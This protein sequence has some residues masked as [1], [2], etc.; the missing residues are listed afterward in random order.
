[1]MDRSISAVVDFI[2]AHIG[3]TV[4]S[5][6]QQS[7]AEIPMIAPFTCAT[8]GPAF[9]IFIYWDTYFMSLG[10]P[11][12]GCGPLVQSNADNFIHMIDT[13][14]YMPNAAVD[15]GMTRSQPPVASRLFALAYE[16]NRDLSWLDKAFGEEK[17]EHAFCTG[18]RQSHTGLNHYGHHATPAEV[19]VF[20]ETFGYR[21]PPCGTPTEESLY[22]AHAVAEAESGWDFCPR[23]ERRAM[24]FDPTDLNSAL[25]WL[26]RDL[27]TFSQA[28]G[29]SEEAAGW[30]QR[31]AERS[32]KMKSL[33][34]NEA[35]TMFLDYDTKNA[36]H[37]PVA[38]AA[39]FWPIWA[40][41]LSPGEARASC[42]S[43]LDALEKDAGIVCCEE[44]PD[45][46]TVYQWGYPNGWPP[47]QWVAVEAMRLCGLEEEAKRVARKYVDCVCA[48]FAKTGNLWE[49]YNVVSG[50]VD[51]HDEYPMPPML[52]WTAGV[53]LSFVETFFAR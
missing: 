28:L 45:D 47:T 31:A 37:S 5:P 29:R 30:S 22:Y 4:V 17:R 3:L 19:R 41:V 34:W 24:D 9:R 8:V 1:M 21:L 2:R 13:F 49:K 11:H 32:A 15:W 50:G 36:R 6:D 43:L 18:F 48:N 33:L 53:F 23:F 44:T 52:G 42:R 39:S 38:S 51:V 10:L 16:S 26:E 46:P 25:L 40:G 7:A 12:C 14:G 27:A 20:A 35:R